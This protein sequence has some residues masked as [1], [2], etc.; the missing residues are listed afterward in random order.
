MNELILNTAEKYLTLYRD[1]CSAI[2]TCHRIDQCKDIIDRSVALA[3]Y[4]KQINDDETVQKFYEVRLRAWRRI[5]ELFKAVDLSAC[6]SVAA[7]CKAIRANFDDQVMR[8]ISD[9]RIYEIL[10]LSAVSDSD[11][12]QAIACELSTGSIAELMRH[13]PAFE[14]ETRK[15]QERIAQQMAQYQAEVERT[16]SQREAEQRETDERERRESKHLTELHRAAEEA[17][18]DVGI[19][20]ERKDRAAMKQVV[21][22]IKH[23][24][25]AVMRRAAFDQHITMQEILRRGLKMWLTAYAYEWPD[26]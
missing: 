8:G 22:L 5:G 9:S 20:L 18:K 12:E 15:G 10:K 16:R 25:H 23:E 7:K 6:E 2:D 11:F 24:V 1:M 3:V 4:C 19:T 17:M 14:E 21:F 13:T 26:E